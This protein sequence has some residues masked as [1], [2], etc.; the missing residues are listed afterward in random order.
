MPIPPN[1]SGPPLLCSEL[2]SSPPISHFHLPAPGHT[3][4]YPGYGRSQLC[5]QSRN[6]PGLSGSPS[7]GVPGH[8]CPSRSQKRGQVGR[9]SSGGSLTKALLLWLVAAHPA[10]KEE[11]HVLMLPLT[12]AMRLQPVALGEAVELPL[13]YC[14]VS[15]LLINTHE[16]FSISPLTRQG[17]FLFTSS[18][19]V[20][21]PFHLMVRTQGGDPWGKERILV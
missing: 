15:P 5:Q 20:S 19:I 7:P 13:N 16:S 1:R 18:L 9:A 14:R 4:A 17:L 11:E 10:A 8:L 2:N 12:E 21:F 6:C 3:A